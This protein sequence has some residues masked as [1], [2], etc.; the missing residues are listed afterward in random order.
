MD[1][2]QQCKDYEHL[3]DRI[4]RACGIMDLYD[5]NYKLKGQVI[6]QGIRRDQKILSMFKEAGE[7]AVKSLD[8]I[9]HPNNT[10]G[11]FK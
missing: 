3:L 7:A 5:G 11:F 4:L 10:Q 2:C 6:L 8:I 1:D 9:I